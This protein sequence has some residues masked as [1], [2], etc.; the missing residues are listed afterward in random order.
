V[1]AKLIVN[2][3]AG[4]DA[5]V[6]HLTYINGQIRRRV[7]LLDIVITTEEGDAASA[8]RDAVLS[9]YDYLF[10]GGG[11]GTLNEVLNGIGAVPGG[12]DAVV[13][14]IVPLGT[15]NDFATALGYPADVTAAVDSLLDAP[16]ACVDIGQLNDRYFINVSAGGF[17]AEVSDAVSPQLKTIA[18]RLAYVIGGASV[19]L[20]HEPLGVRVDS[21]V[22]STSMSIN[23]FAVCNSRLIGGGRLIA[24][25]ARVDDGLLDVYLV[26]AMS[27]LDFLGLL[28]RLSD[29]EHVSDES[30]TYFRAAELDLQFD[31]S[32][33]VNT[34]G[35]VLDT[36]RCHYQVLPGAL[37]V[38]RPT[39]EAA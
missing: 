9:G 39:R 16:A 24:P 38:L 23:M 32:V 29:G 22:H 25:D 4:T 19:V 21:S 17:I 33:K 13:L 27:K 31:R 34:D 12:F 15:G 8:A 7:G 36:H 5:A 11:D 3:T 10:V 26:E 1:K 28:A 30:V 37:R 2:P 35:Q 6:R 14:G 20:E 18:G